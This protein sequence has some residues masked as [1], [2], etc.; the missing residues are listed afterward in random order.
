MRKYF[1]GTIEKVRQQSGKNLKLVWKTQNPGHVNCGTYNAPQ[2]NYAI[3]SPEMDNYC[4]NLHPVFDEVSKNYSSLI[5]YQ[6][7]AECYT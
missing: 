1:P 5:D 3:A 2:K 6:V 7:R 4:W